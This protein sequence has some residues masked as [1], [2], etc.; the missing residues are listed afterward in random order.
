MEANKSF[1][2]YMSAFS[3]EYDNVLKKDIEAI[4]SKTDDRVKLAEPYQQLNENIIRVFLGKLRNN[5]IDFQE[6]LTYSQG[7]EIGEYLQEDELGDLNE[8]I[9]KL[10]Q[11]MR[12]DN[13]SLNRI[14]RI[15]FRDIPEITSVETLLQSLLERHHPNMEIKIND[16]HFNP[17]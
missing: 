16:I 17:S 6:S 11:Y 12:S 2:D 1:L 8:K 14:I 3:E 9:L 5:E 13:I 10:R 15:I 7:K 4:I